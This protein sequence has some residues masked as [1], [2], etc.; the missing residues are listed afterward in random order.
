MKTRPLTSFAYAVTTVMSATVLSAT[1]V[2]AAEPQASMVA[3]VDSSVR[4]WFA[5]PAVQAAITASNAA[6]AGLDNAQILDLDTRW[7]AEIGRADAPTVSRVTGSALSEQLRERVAD[8][9]GTITEIILMDNRGLNVA[10]S[11]VT[12]DYWQGDEAKFQQ[13]FPLGAGAVHVGEIEFDESTQTYQAQVSVVI[14]DAA[15]GAPIGAATV[16]LNAEAF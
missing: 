4:V 11:A 10:V 6:H 1:A 15:S 5:E 8:S 16:G 13:T 2:L 12:S 3:F 7:R 14:V 9:G